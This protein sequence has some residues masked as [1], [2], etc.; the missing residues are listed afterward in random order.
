MSERSHGFPH[1]DVVVVH[2]RVD[3]PLTGDLFCLLLRARGAGVGVR[4]GGAGDG[5]QDGGAK[6]GVG[7]G[8]EGT[9]WPFGDE[10]TDK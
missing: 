3:Q 8:S 5:R 1:S 7:V 2:A 9:N 10:M 4:V 6:V